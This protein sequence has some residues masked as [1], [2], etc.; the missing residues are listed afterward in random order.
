M[1]RAQILPGGGGIPAMRPCFFL[2][3]PTGLDDKHVRAV[4]KEGKFPVGGK[5][6]NN[7]RRSE[8]K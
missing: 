5:E 8:K 6:T 7:I 4:A 1:K 3:W 2:L